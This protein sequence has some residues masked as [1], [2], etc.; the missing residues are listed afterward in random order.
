[1]G[2]LLPGLEIRHTELLLRPSPKQLSS[3]KMS[4]LSGSIEMRPRQVRSEATVRV[5]LPLVVS[6]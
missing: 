6:I 2:E 5:T 4:P 1:V 3:A